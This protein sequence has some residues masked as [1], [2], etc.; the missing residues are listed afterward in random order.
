MINK[1]LDLKQFCKFEFPTS[2]TGSVILPK[3]SLVRK[4]ASLVQAGMSTYYYNIKG[5]VV[6]TSST[7][8]NV[9]KKNRLKILRI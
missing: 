7:T 5:Y 8:Y 6:F 3:L 9:T 2:L 1:V 4:G